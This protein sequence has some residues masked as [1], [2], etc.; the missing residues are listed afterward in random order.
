MPRDT[1]SVFST[2]R[3]A[4]ARYAEVIL[5]NACAALMQTKAS[6]FPRGRGNAF[7]TLRGTKA[8]YAAWFRVA[9]SQPNVAQAPVMLR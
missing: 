3:G 8:R 4:N 7:S 1:V 6:S 9:F 2:P 5:G